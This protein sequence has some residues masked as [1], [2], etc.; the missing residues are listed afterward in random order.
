MTRAI[1]CRREGLTRAEM[2]AH[3]TAAEIQTDE[4]TPRGL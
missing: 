2:D 3:I 1:Q 4:F